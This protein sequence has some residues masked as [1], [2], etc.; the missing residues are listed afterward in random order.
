MDPVSLIGSRIITAIS[1]NIIATTINTISATSTSIYN[2]CY[3][4]NSCITSCPDGKRLIETLKTLDLETTISVINSLLEA[5]DHTKNSKATNI[6]IESLKD[7]IVE[8]EKELIDAK[9]HID[10]NNSIW[11]GTYWRSYDLLHHIDRLKNM[12]VILHNRIELFVLS[13]K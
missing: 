13:M 6:V 1:I 3:G 2:I 4:I 9:S 10:Y 7:I 8:I 11:V 5:S 12:S